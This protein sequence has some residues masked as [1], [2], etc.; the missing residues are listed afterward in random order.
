MVYPPAEADTNE[1]GRSPPDSGYRRGRYTEAHQV[2]GWSVETSVPIRT[3]GAEGNLVVKPE[4]YSVPNGSGGSIGAI[5]YWLFWTGLGS[6]YDL[7][8][9]DSGSTRVDGDPLVMQSADVYSAVVSP[10]AG[11]VIRERPLS[12]VSFDPT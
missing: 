6:V 2:P 10:D 8:V 3:G 5:R 7:R 12:T 11:P 9:L 1:A 4:I